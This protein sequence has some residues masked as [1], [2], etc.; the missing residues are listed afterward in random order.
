MQLVT[1]T[2]VPPPGSVHLL[3][4]V[5]DFETGTS[6]NSVAH[7]SLHVVIHPSE[8]ELAKDLDLLPARNGPSE[9]E[10][11][12][13]LRHKGDTEHRF[14]RTESDFVSTPSGYIRY[15]QLFCFDHSQP[16]KQQTSN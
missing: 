8:S 1:A 3:A 16:S 5:R 6:H 7:G 9:S 10:C 15:I 4:F 14:P 11:L 12:C 2:Q 13:T